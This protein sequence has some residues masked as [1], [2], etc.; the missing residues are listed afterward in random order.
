MINQQE[1]LLLQP[2]TGE[3]STTLGSVHMKLRLLTFVIEGKFIVADY[4][5][6]ILRLDLMR[7]YGL[8]V[9]LR[10][11][12]LRAPCDDILLLAMETTAVQQIRSEVDPVQELMKPCQEML[13]AEQIKSLKKTLLDYGDVFAQHESDSGRTNLI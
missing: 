9:D 3:S 4:D 1:Q 8:I 6:C 10:R 13:S 11:G 2:A 12:L 5:E 7:K